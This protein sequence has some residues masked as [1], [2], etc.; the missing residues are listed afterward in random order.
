MLL[1]PGEKVWL[2]TLIQ[3]FL[4]MGTG[5]VSPDVLETEMEAEGKTERLVFHDRYS[6]GLP[7]IRVRVLYTAI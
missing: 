5:P 1:C 7:S 3:C 4:T 2:R 6:E